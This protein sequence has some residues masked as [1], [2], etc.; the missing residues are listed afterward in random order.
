MGPLAVELGAQ[1]FV[2]MESPSEGSDG[3]AV[4]DVEDGISCL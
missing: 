4:A 1:L 2:M 3:L